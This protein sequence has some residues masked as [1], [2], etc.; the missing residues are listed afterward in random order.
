MKKVV[1]FNE[2]ENARGW[3]KRA[4]KATWIATDGKIFITGC[5][6][7]IENYLQKGWKII[8]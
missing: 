4:V 2:L 3:A 7:A 8:Y 5:P 1:K 6:A